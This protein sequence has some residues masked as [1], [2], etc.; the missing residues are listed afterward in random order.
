MVAT[1]LGVFDLKCKRYAVADAANCYERFMSVF[2]PP[3]AFWARG[4]TRFAH[5]SWRD[6]PLGA[7]DVR[8]TLTPAAVRAV[9][10][11]ED[12]GS[13]GVTMSKLHG[14]MAITLS[15][16]GPER[17]A[18]AIA[19]YERALA[20]LRA[21]LP[22]SAA[23]DLREAKFQKGMAPL[24]EVASRP[25]RARACLAAAQQLADGAR[26]ADA[27]ERA[28]LLS[29][30]NGGSGT[31]ASCCSSALGEGWMSRAELEDAE[32]QWLDV[33]HTRSDEAAAAR[34]QL[35]GS[36]LE[37]MMSGGGAEDACRTHWLRR[38]AALPGAAAAFKSAAMLAC[39]TCGAPPGDGDTGKLKLCSG[40]CGGRVA[41]CGR[42]CQTA[43]WRRHKPC[44]AGAQASSA[45]A[46]LKDGTCAVC[47]EPLLPCGDDDDAAVMQSA[48]DAVPPCCRRVVMIHCL[49]LA[50][51]RCE[52]RHGCAVCS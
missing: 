30:L 36:V 29:E 6:T 17:N 20:A 4:I 26:G 32:R 42:A 43:D 33:A 18:Y 35:C 21:G 1:L 44:C 14:N 37:G 39:R 2:L 25:D 41:Y 12:G 52:A 24:H 9:A 22:R 49:H 27:A 40:G 34:V 46:A 11:T 15:Y 38:A 48:V 5:A 16:G 10:P 31:V 8:I 28:K 47:H 45:E 13:H 51:A 19:C 50:H 7:D 23:R 3:H